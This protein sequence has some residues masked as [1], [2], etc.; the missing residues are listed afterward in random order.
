MELLI[1]KY[2]LDDVLE[3]DRESLEIELDRQEYLRNKEDEYFDYMRDCIGI[4]GMNW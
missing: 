3:D 1:D 4:R 2:C